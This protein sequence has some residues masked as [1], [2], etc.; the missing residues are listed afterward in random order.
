[1]A[2]VVMRHLLRHPVICAALDAPSQRALEA[3][4]PPVH[5]AR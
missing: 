1:M 3:L 4:P 2:A 5:P